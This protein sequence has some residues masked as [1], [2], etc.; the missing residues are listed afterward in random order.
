[1]ATYHTFIEVPQ[2]GGW[3]LVCVSTSV[4]GMNPG[5]ST[6][7]GGMDPGVCTS[8]GGMDPGVCKYLSWVDGPWCV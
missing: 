5:V 8:F 1:M 6:S 2:L 4:G 3:T 7:F